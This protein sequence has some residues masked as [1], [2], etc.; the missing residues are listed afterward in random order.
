VC[1]LMSRRGCG[2]VVTGLVM[3]ASYADFLAWFMKSTNGWRVGANLS[4]IPVPGKGVIRSGF[5]YS[6]FLE[7]VGEGR[8][9]WYGPFEDD[10]THA[11]Q[12][13][14]RADGAA[15]LLVPLLLY[16]KENKSSS[17]MRKH[18]NHKRAVQLQRIFPES[19]RIGVR[20]TTS[21]GAGD[22]R[23]FHS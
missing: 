5:C 20:R 9:H 18:Y 3:L 11:F 12:Y 10:I 23:V 19:A 14:T 22:A 1:M 7:R 13:G 6:L 15:P 8:E 17:G 2:K 16:T 4:S 21:N